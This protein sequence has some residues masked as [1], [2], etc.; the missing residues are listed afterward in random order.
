MTVTTPTGLLDETRARR[1]I[2]DYT[3]TI[4]EGPLSDWPA[5]FTDPCLYRITTR[6]N[7]AAKLPLSIMLCDNH[8]MLYDRVEAIERANVFEPHYYRHILSDSRIRRNDVEGL[9]IETS[10]SCI[11]TM[12]DGRVTQFAT[13]RYADHIVSVGDTYRFRSRIVVLDSCSVDTLL[14]IPL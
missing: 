9:L 10:F 6:E 1:L 13:G 8:G 5:Y 12:L 14:A 11:R 3:Y 4:D 2:A 7:E